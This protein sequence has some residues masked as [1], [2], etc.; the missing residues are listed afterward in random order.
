MD[1]NLN[2][3]SNDILI[4][5]YNNYK[6]VL[7]EMEEL[8]KNDFENDASILYTL[9][10]V[11]RPKTKVALQ[12]YFNLKLESNLFYFSDNGTNFANIIINDETK[13]LINDYLEGSQVCINYE[14]NL[15]YLK[16]GTTDELFNINFLCKQFIDALSYI[17]NLL[18]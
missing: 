11:V 2:S 10:N 5:Q 13:H 9:K 6:N 17:N 14:N 18:K 1:N 7:N 8:E 16:L 4:E 15:I 3:E 12:F